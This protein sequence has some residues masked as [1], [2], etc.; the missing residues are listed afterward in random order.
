MPLRSMMW[1][2]AAVFAAAAPAGA[3]APLRSEA[4]HPDPCASAAA[5]FVRVEPGEP[6][7]RCRYGARGPG[8][9]GLS[10]L[11]LPVY[12]PTT[13][14]PGTHLV[15]VPG[16]PGP[17]PGE[18]W[19]GWEWRLLRTDFGPDA[20]SVHR[21]LELLYPPFAARV[22]RLETRLAAEGIPFRRRET[23]RSPERQAY[24]FQQGRSRN[25]ILATTTLTSMHS[26]VDE[27][28]RSAG[29]AVDY[30]VPARRLRRFHEIAAEV[31]LEGFGADSHD[32]GHVFLPP[33]PFTAEEVA[34]LRT[35]PP[36]AH[37]TLATGRP[38]GEDYSLPLNQ[39]REEV[40]RFA[41]E[42]YAWTARLAPREPELR[43]TFAGIVP[44][45]PATQEAA[46]RRGRRV[47]R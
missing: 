32:P 14:M 34:V 31:G 30:D 5:G 28:G 15:A 42:P 47:S 38:A 7:L 27:G 17:R 46:P 2:L 23:W 29:R 20:R 24:L 3:Q 37:V 40:R 16:L 35:L 39:L 25:G 8:R 9:F 19:E 10:Y 45:P 21:S 1:M 13:P 43:I 33:R 41:G 44:P 4:V 26:F 18:S 11:D 12:R 22:L 36:V 6:E